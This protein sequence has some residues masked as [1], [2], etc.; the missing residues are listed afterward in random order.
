MIP[1][2]ITCSGSFY[3]GASSSGSSEIPGQAACAGSP[4]TLDQPPATSPSHRGVRRRCDALPALAKFRDFYSSPLLRG[5]NKRASVCSALSPS[6][7]G[8]GTSG[9]AE[10]GSGCFFGCRKSG[11]SWQARSEVWMGE[12]K[13]SVIGFSFLRLG[14]M[15]V[16][17]FPFKTQPSQGPCVSPSVPPVHFLIQMKNVRRRKWE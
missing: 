7:G 16:S 6:P 3:Y 17:L 4:G 1:T 11:L 5:I 8:K 14:A 12:N 9:S 15:L 13:W 2:V 10:D